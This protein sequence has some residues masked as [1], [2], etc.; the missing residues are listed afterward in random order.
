MCFWY[1]SPSPPESPSPRADLM[2]GR[3]STVPS[4]EMKGFA[5]EALLGLGDRS[6]AS[7]SR[8]T[9][10]REKDSDRNSGR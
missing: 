7:R 6:R 2:A 5:E 1:P 10:Q 3:D 9:T 4:S 8:A